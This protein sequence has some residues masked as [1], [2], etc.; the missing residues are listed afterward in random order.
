MWP[1]ELP[2]TNWRYT[3]SLFPLPLPPLPSRSYF[4]AAKPDINVSWSLIEQSLDHTVHRVLDQGEDPSTIL[5]LWGKSRVRGVAKTGN[6]TQIK[7]LTCDCK[8]QIPMA[9]FLVGCTVLTKASLVAK[10]PG[11]CDGLGTRLIMLACISCSIDRQLSLHCNMLCSSNKRRSTLFCMTFS[12]ISLIQNKN[13]E[14][15]SINEVAIGPAVCS[16]SVN[17][18]TVR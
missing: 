8:S 3:Y 11:L 7:N 4:R 18:S 1:G 10:P 6:H 14:A 17:S 15:I 9:D 13:F 12:L 2:C 16:Y 5:E